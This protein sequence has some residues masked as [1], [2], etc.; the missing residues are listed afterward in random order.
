MGHGRD[1]R[2]AARQH[3]LSEGAKRIS[4]YLHHGREKELLWRCCSVE[5]A[6]PMLGA[7][8]RRMSRMQRM[9]ISQYKTDKCECEM[10][11]PPCRMHGCAESL[12]LYASPDRAS[13][14]ARFSPILTSTSPRLSYT[15]NPCLSLPPLGAPAEP[16]LECPWA[17]PGAPYQHLRGPPIPTSPCPT[18]ECSDDSEPPSPELPEAFRGDRGSFSSLRHRH[19]PP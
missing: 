15:V 18:F 19:R 14:K 1:G 8:W 12:S 13:S 17:L 7:A 5:A 9:R 10:L 11:R 16:S 4:Q 6:A 2:G 3:A